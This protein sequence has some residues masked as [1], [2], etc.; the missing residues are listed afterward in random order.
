MTNSS[1]TQSH[2]LIIVEG[3]SDKNFLNAILYSIGISEI[4]IQETKGIGNF[5]N[6][7]GDSINNFVRENKDAAI[8]LI[9]DRDHALNKDSQKAK[10]AF[11]KHMFLNEKELKH[12]DIERDIKLKNTEGNTLVFDFSLYEMPGKDIED[13]VIEGEELEDLW[14][15]TLSTETKKC[16]EQLL[17]CLSL[18]MPQDAIG[19]RYEHAVLAIY[20]KYFSSFGD[21][22]LDN[23]TLAEA[24]F[25]VKHEAYKPLKHHIEL[26]F[27]V[28]LSP[29]TDT[30][31]TPQ[32]FVCC[33]RSRYLASYIIHRF[34]I[35]IMQF[36]RVSIKAF[37]GIQDLEFYDLGRINLLVGQNNCGKTLIFNSITELDDHYTRLVHEK[38]IMGF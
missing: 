8:L 16:I 33:R 34:I 22:K 37:R 7:V 11:F 25:N 13:I 38:L 32:A 23:A 17:T 14:R 35:S 3:N 24:L 9:W 12:R 5:K 26:F 21:G 1:T 31:P 36:R 28:K 2:K 15:Q 20:P 6:V 27:D 18:E 30:P 10:Q 4:T 19:K 29:A